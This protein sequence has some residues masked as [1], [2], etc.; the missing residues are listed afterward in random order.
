MD[1]PE[2]IVVKR[3]NAMDCEIA[4]ASVIY[5]NNLPQI[6]HVQSIPKCQ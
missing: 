6:T 2:I 1:L 5:M 3:N 4:N